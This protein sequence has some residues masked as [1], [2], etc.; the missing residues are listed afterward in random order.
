MIQTIEADS[1]IRSAFF[2]SLDSTGSC[3]PGDP[4]DLLFISHPA[5][6]PSGGSFWIH[7]NGSPTAQRFA[8]LHDR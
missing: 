4:L 1:D 5:W 2:V 6:L 8:E 7:T 3:N